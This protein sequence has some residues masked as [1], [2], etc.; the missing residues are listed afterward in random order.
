MLLYIWCNTDYLFV[1]TYNIFVCES[2]LGS[3][4]T[5]YHVMHNN[6]D[7]QFRPVPCRFH[8]EDLVVKYASKTQFC[9]HI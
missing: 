5:G 6:H 4:S 8:Q 3:T 1:E 9:D 7:N 2:L